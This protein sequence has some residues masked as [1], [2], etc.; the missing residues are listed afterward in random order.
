MINPVRSRVFSLVKPMLLLA[1]AVC[2]ML[3]ANPAA[4]QVQ[5]GDA[6]K[7]ITIPSFTELAKKL[8]PVTDGFEA[9]AG[10]GAG[11]CGSAVQEG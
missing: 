5:P 11:C 2:C 4:A 6:V 1:F 9:A 10:I 3:A 8:M 7:T